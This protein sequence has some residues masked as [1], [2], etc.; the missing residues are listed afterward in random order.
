MNRIFFI[1]LFLLG[2]KSSFAQFTTGISGNVT[3]NLGQPVSMYPIYAS[4]FDVNN[5]ETFYTDALGNYVGQFS[6]PSAATIDSIFVGIEDNCYLQGYQFKTYY[7]T[8]GGNIVADFVVCDSVQAPPVNCNGL[9]VNFSSFQQ[10][11]GRAHV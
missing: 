9:S 1:G 7:P 4:A 8:S 2:L 10:E 5:V 6:V 3:D 11:I